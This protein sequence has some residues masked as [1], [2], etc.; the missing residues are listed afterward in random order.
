MRLSQ[1][2]TMGMKKFQMLTQTAAIVIADDRGK[3]MVPNVEGGVANMTDGRGN[4]NGG[5]G[6]VAD[7]GVTQVADGDAVG[8]GGTVQQFL[9]CAQPLVICLDVDYI[10]G[11][12]ERLKLHG[13]SQT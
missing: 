7:G 2:A 1:I 9:A 6:N 11:L 4:K 13:A 12:R 10:E 5:G 3:Q 8:G